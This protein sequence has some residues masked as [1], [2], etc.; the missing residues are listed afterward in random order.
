MLYLGR[1]IL[2]EFV[3]VWPFVACA[4]RPSFA[5]CGLEWY[6]VLNLAVADHNRF[7]DLSF[8]SLCEKLHE[9]NFTCKLTIRK[10][11]RIS[12]LLKVR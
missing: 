1:F 9:F 11:L 3:D 10:V 5:L 12:L 6:F 8:I 7:C 4:A 2:V